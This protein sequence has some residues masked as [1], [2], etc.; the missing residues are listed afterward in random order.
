MWTVIKI[1]AVINLIGCAIATAAGI[2][3]DI[4]GDE[5]DEE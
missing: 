4:T 5:G 1:W 3:R 2:Y